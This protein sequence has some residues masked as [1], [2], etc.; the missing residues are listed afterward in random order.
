MRTQ[1]DRLREIADAIR[2]KEGSTEPI[3]AKDFAGRILALEMSRLP[4]G[5]HTINL[6]TNDPESGA[7]A[8]GGAVFDGAVITI[9]AK[10]C[11]GHRFVAWQE[12]GRTVSEELEYTFTANRDMSL[13][14]VFELGRPSRLPKGYTEVEYISNPDHTYIADFGLAANFLSGTRLELCIEL[15]EIPTQNQTIIGNR[16]LY[17]VATSTSGV[18][19]TQS[20]LNVLWFKS[21]TALALQWGYSN[22]SP[23]GKVS[24]SIQLPSGY[25]RIIV[26]HP[27][28]L[29]QINDVTE[30]LGSA[31]PSGQS[32]KSPSLFAY[33][34]SYTLR[35]SYSS[36]TSSGNNQG[37][38]P[39]NFKLYSLKAYASTK[40]E[41]GELLCDYVP[42]VN[43]ANVAGI[44]DL[45][46][47][48]FFTS[49]EDGK[50]F[51]AGPAVQ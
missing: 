48:A 3:P 51:T 23:G 9:T 46:A 16:Y 15:L 7:V 39:T 37:E 34:Y 26:D 49:S 43:A 21:S 2:E 24:T 41:T 18:F 1:E 13:M 22:S 40:E 44:Y 25:M 5:T 47:Q 8:G 36:P 6:Q 4:E 31:G 17:D 38:Y 12:G 50:A 30:Q 45:V 35:P 29:F 28:S 42:C 14:G 27:K 33:S 32:V 11:D 19:E 10:P 20:N